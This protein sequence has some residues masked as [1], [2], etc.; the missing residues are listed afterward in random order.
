[1]SHR[2]KHSRGQ[3]HRA[4]SMA[5]QRREMRMNNS[6]KALFA[7]GGLATRAIFISILAANPS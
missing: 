7:A 1:V 6:M 4:M 5:G 3:E 2:S